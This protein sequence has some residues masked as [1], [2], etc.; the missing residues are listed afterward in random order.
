MKILSASATVFILAITAFITLSLTMPETKSAVK[1]INTDPKIQVAILLDVSGSM[2]GLIEQAKAQLWNMVSVMG[3]AKCENGIPKIEIALYEYG[4]STNDA[5]AGFIKQ[6]S[7]FTSDLDQLSQELFKLT[8]NG[9]EEYCGQVI[10]ASI[11]ELNWDVSSSNYKVIFIAGNEDFLQGSIHYTKACDEANKKGVIVNTIYCGDRLQG[12]KEHW[13]LSG[14]CGNGSFTNI[15]QDAKVEDIPTPYDSALVVLNNKLNGTYLYYGEA[16]ALNFSKQQKVDQLNSSMNNSAGLKRAT[17]KSNP[18]LYRNGGWDLVDA[19][20][21]DSSILPRV[22]MKTLPDSLK[23]KSRE[24]LKQIV[25]VKA[26]ER[27][28]IQ[29]EIQSISTQRQNYISSEKAKAATGNN[30]ATLETEV[31]KIIKSQVKRFKMS[32]D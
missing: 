3:K 15:N 30:T 24:E 19:N 14:E 17:A 26:N 18:N 11:N 29:K 21:T 32:I 7:G 22:D 4:R 23:N 12:I 8:I 9:S 6:I 16:G 2:G 13:N 31:E 25:T 10:Y 28:L 27:G 5:K 20:S 1:T